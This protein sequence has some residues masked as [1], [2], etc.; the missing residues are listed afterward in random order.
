MSSD[1]HS[2]VITVYPDPDVS[3]NISVNNSRP[4][5]GDNVRYT[6]DV[7]NNSAGPASG[8]SVD[9]DVFPELTYSSH[10]DGGVGSYNSGTGVW[11]IGILNGGQT[12][13]LQIDYT[14]AIQSSFGGVKVNSA[15]VSLTE[16]DPDLS[17]NTDTVN[18]RIVESDLEVTK[19]VDNNIPTGGDFINYTLTVTN[20]GTRDATNIEIT[21]ILNSNLNY[22][23]DTSGGTYNSG[24]GIWQISN[25]AAGNSTS[26]DIRVEVDPAIPD[27]RVGNT[28]R[29]TAVDQYDPITSNDS[30]TV[31]IYI[32]TTDLW[33]GFTVSD[34]T[35]M[36]NDTITYTIRVRNR[37][38][39]PTNSVTVTGIELASG[40]TYTGQ[41]V[42]VGSYS[43]GTW[44]IGTMNP[45][46]D[47][48]M[49]LTATV[50]PVSGGVT[51]HS[52]TATVSGSLADY[53]PGNNTQTA[54]FTIEN[55]DLTI[56][57]S[58]DNPTPNVGDTV[59]F[60]LDVTHISGPSTATNVTVA[61]LLPAGLSYVSDDGGGAYNSGTGLWT[62]ASIAPSGT[63]TLTITATVT[64]GNA[65]ANTI[66]NTANYHGLRSI[67]NGHDQQHR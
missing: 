13:T 35:P 53:L 23:S 6:V 65:P 4:F 52:A 5:E 61:D 46:A 45:G 16:S 51:T 30:D 47:H 11:T 2:D 19:T 12:V 40:V 9:T 55:A 3:V 1:T 42:P 41:S 62:I 10:N 29:M 28:A 48:T 56:S 49:T 18:I 34:T 50:D 21:D 27:I 20:N 64:T 37:G 54:T 24:T 22:D 67:R 63:A 8:V 44:T 59:I 7:T 33:L 32:Q 14:V 25:L 43:S 57:K 39:L 38:F 66:T 17:N 60:T 31:D 26:I 58:V 15:V 36:E